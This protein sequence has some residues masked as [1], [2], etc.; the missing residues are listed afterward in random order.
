MKLTGLF[1]RRVLLSEDLALLLLSQ[2][3]SIGTDH[4]D[5][6]D[7]EADKIDIVPQP[8]DLESVGGVRYRRLYQRLLQSE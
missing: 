8:L 5:Q 2:I 3:K 7:V 4:Q 1:G 6:G